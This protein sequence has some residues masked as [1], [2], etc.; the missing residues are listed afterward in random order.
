MKQNE[1][2]LIH[3]KDYQ[4]MTVQLLERANLA[5]EI[6]D[7]WARIALKP[8]LV[9]AADA[10]EGAVTH[11]EI[12]AGT[13]EYLQKHGFRNVCVMEGSWVGAKTGPALKVSGI[14]AVCKKYQIPFFD[15]Q[16][17]TSHKVTAKGMELQICDQV[18]ETDFLINLPVLKGHCQTMLTCAMKN[19]KGLIPNT[20]KRRFHTMGLHKPIAHLSAAIRQNFIIVD[21]I[22]G[23]LDFEEGGNPVPMDRIFCCKDPVLCDSF[24]C[25]TLGLSLDDVPYIR[26]GEQLGVGCS[27]LSKAEITALNP[28]S[29]AQPGRSTRKIRNLEAYICPKD[30]CSACYG[31]LIHALDK[32]DRLGELWGHQQKICI[33]QG[34][35][36]KTGEI[37]IGSCT[38]NCSQSLPGCPPTAEAILQFLQE[39]WI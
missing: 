10:S 1:I 35:R 4:A 26:I 18:A 5:S 9:L 39:H 12:V 7:R 27:D 2:M 16:K 32:M 36:G 19:L 28:C 25:Q 38:R 20:E 14:D 17:D 29:M 8:N 13:L 15:L 33:G 11:P 34:Y 22:C 24:G 37:G 3:G 6:G 23:D 31:M 30:A 21:N